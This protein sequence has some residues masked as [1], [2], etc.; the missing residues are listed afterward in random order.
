MNTAFL[1]MARYNGLP[2][3]PVDVVCKDYFPHLS[4]EK[5]LRKAL[6]GEI[7]L[8]IVRMES[9]QKTAKGVPINDLAAYLDKQ[10]ETARK[11]CAQLKRSA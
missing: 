3:I 11:E 7:S 8:P 6:A 1:L 4:V 9:S 10:I 5:F 2:V